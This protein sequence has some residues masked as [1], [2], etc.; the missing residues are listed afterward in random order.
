MTFPRLLRATGLVALCAI[1]LPFG[2]E[3]GSAAEPDAIVVLAPV[4]PGPAVETGEVEEQSRVVFQRPGQTAGDLSRDF[5]VLA[6]Q[7]GRVPRAWLWDEPL[8]CPGQGH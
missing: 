4:A 7:D 6:G 1:A 3:S 5:V 2:P 8:G